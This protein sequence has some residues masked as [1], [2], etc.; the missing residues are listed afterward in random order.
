MSV[1]SRKT[2]AHFQINLILLIHGHLYFVQSIKLSSLC[3][4]VIELYF[5]GYSTLIVSSSLLFWILKHYFNE[6][7]SKFF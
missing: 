5:F 2:F 7:H 1:Y 6:L 3:K 4:T